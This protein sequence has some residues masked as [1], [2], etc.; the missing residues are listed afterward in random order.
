MVLND[1]KQKIVKTLNESQI[2]IDAIYYVMREVMQEVDIA[3]QRALQEEEQSKQN[4][5]EEKQ[6]KEEKEGE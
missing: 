1:L 6:D 5:I 3:Y 2:S 4:T